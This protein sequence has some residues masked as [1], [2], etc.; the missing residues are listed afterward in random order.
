MAHLRRSLRGSPPALS[1]AA[2]A[3]PRGSKKN[4][5]GRLRQRADSSVAVGQCTSTSSPSGC[6]REHQH[7]LGGR[8][9]SSADRSPV[10]GSHAPISLIRAPRRASPNGG[11]SARARALRS[12]CPSRFFARTGR[13]G[14]NR[15]L[16]LFCFPRAS[17][18]HQARSRRTVRLSSHGARAL[19]RP[20][21]TFPLSSGP[22][23][24]THGRSCALSRRVHRLAA[25]DKLS[26]GTNTRMHA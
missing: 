9:P 19:G 18:H 20:V 13:A 16:G 12:A 8:R 26:S 14:A 6:P 2:P 10:Y 17:G 3:W 11:R 1:A 21:Q 25:A 15:R 7:A 22:T 5:H 23:A 24:W 4:H